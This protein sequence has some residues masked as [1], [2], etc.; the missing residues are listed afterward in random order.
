MKAI[1]LFIIISISTVYAQPSKDYFSSQNN[2]ITEEKEAYASI[3]NTKNASQASPNFDVSYYRCE[4][5]VDPAVRYI[6]G[7]VTSYFKITAST[8]NIAFDLIDSLVV[9][10]VKR[11]NNL[12]SFDHSNN[13]L[14]IN[15]GTIISSGVL[16]SVCIYYQGVPPGSG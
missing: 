8:A 2:I 14:T 3:K 7:E 13:T 15:F 10:S 9:D 4:W 6:R 16:D 11:N 12:L 1:F 5:E